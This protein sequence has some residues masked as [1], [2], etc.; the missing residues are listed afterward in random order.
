MNKK[1][2]LF[3]LTGFVAVL[4][5]S[6]AFAMQ[7]P[8]IIVMQNEECGQ[9][10]VENFWRSALEKLKQFDA[11]ELNPLTWE[12]AISELLLDQQKGMWSKAH[13]ELMD[14][15]LQ[16]VNGDDDLKLIVSLLAFE[17]GNTH[18]LEFLSSSL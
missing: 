6:S 13:Q 15:C 10:G 7:Q 1:I 14:Y 5:S 18:V 8:E 4:L 9:G 17:R 16:V 2:K 12:Q 11:K 3:F